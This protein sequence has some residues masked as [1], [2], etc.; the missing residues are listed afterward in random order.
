MK[1]SKFLLAITLAIALSA[2]DKTVEQVPIYV[3]QASPNPCTD[4]V[5]INYFGGPVATVDLKFTDGKGSVLYENAAFPNGTTVQIDLRD[6]EKGTYYL[7]F[8][9]G[10]DTYTQTILKAQ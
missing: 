10:G 2:C 9:Y 1:I 6:R 7:Q 5:Q 8:S 3:V 4:V